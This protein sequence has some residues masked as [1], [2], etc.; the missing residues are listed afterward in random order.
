[1]TGQGCRLSTG[2]A[3]FG[4]L[5]ALPGVN[6]VLEGKHSDGDLRLLGSVG[7]SGVYVG[8]DISED[9]GWPTYRFQRPN[10]VE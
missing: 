7:D 6:V 1:M 9:V 8:L 5:S 4:G 3:T 2:L 10:S